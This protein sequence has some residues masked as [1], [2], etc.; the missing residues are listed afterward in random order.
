MSQPPR[1][2]ISKTSKQL[3]DPELSKLS[4]LF[5]AHN[6]IPLATQYLEIGHIE[7]NN[8]A[9]NNRSVIDFRL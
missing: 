1:K 7:A 6:M 9:H 3:S 2:S 5:Y 8:I 4:D